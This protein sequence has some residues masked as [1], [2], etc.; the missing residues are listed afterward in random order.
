MQTVYGV[1]SQLAHEVMMAYWQLYLVPDLSLAALE[2]GSSSSPSD[3]VISAAAAEYSL[4]GDTIRDIFREILELMCN[5]YEDYCVA[6]DDLFTAERLKTIESERERLRTVFWHC[7]DI[8]SNK[9]RQQSLPHGTPA[10]HDCSIVRSA[11]PK[12]ILTDAHNAN[13]Y[14]G[15]RYDDGQNPP[16]YHAVASYFKVGFGLRFWIRKSYSHVAFHLFHPTQTAWNYIEEQ[17]NKVEKYNEWQAYGRLWTV[18]NDTMRSVE[19]LRC[20]RR[21][22]EEMVEKGTAAELDKR[23]VAA[24]EFYKQAAVEVEYVL[25]RIWARMETL[26][27][28]YRDGHGTVPPSEYEDCVKVARELNNEHRSTLARVSR[29]LQIKHN[30]PA[31]LTRC[32]DEAKTVCSKPN[33]GW[34]KAHTQP[35]LW[36]GYNYLAGESFKPVS[37]SDA[38]SS[39]FQ[40]CGDPDGGY[41]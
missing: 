27:Q 2:D 21:K 1:T 3:E 30:V 13:V 34:N 12:L 14:T 23:I 5:M 32:S 9:L 4:A 7:R 16:F 39:H 18:A 28:A 20:M 11:R 26:F 33:P 17:R 15:I 38:I 10:S 35:D 31:S 40:V 6:G 37:F 8:A 22:A 25:K 41:L 29:D 19:T 24:E 36:K